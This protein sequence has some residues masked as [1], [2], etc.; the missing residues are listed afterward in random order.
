VFFEQLEA[1]RR[2]RQQNVE[3]F[4]D[5]EQLFVFWRKLPLLFEKLVELGRIG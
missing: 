3:Q 4:V 1:R 5:D 2:F